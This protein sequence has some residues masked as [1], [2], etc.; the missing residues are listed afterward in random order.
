MLNKAEL[1]LCNNEI[2]KDILG[3]KIL[4]EESS[5]FSALNYAHE[6]SDK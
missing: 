5:K 3:K 4:Q 1:A 6:L 2:E